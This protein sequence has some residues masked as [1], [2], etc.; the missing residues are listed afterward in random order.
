[1][2]LYAI[3]YTFNIEHYVRHYFFLEVFLFYIGLYIFYIF[4]DI[5][6]QS[7]HV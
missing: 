6:T 1:M 7:V 2:I 5:G 3:V 4:N